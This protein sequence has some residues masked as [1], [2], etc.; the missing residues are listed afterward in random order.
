LIFR[1]QGLD[2]REFPDLM[3][4]RLGIGSAERSAA[5]SARLRSA[6]IARPAEDACVSA[7]AAAIRLSE[8]VFIPEILEGTCV[9]VECQDNRLA[10]L[11]FPPAW[12]A[13]WLSVSLQRY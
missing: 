10:A 2:F 13:R 7:K 12:L 6:A 9:S 8:R 4:Q 1:D 3:A 11:I 5:T